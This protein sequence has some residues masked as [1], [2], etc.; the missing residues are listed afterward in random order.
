MRRTP[1]HEDIQTQRHR[2]TRTRKHRWAR[3]AAFT[4]IGLCTLGLLAALGAFAYLKVTMSDTDRGALA[5][6]ILDA[7]L[8]GTFHID[9]VGW[10]WPVHV[11]IEGVVINAPDGKT[12]AR[13]RSIHAHLRLLPLLRRRIVVDDIDVVEPNVTI[14]K[15][16]K[17]RVDI[18]TAFDAEEPG[19]E[20][21]EQAKP[22]TGVE[23]LQALRVEL[24]DIAVHHAQFQIDTPDVRIQAKDI[25]IKD[26]SL[27]IQGET[28]GLSL[29]LDTVPALHAGGALVL[30]LA[31]LHVEVRE[32]VYH[33]GEN[34]KQLTVDRVNVDTPG[35]SVDAGG[36]F[37]ATDTAFKEIHAHA[38]FALDSGFAF[39]HAQ[40]APPV[41]QGLSGQME[42][43]VKLEGVGPSRH[44]AVDIDGNRLAWRKLALA[45]LST[46]GYLRGSNVTLDT[47]ALRL[48]DALVNVHG[49]MTMRP[50]PGVAIGMHDLKLSAQNLAVQRVLGPFVDQSGL[51]PERVTMTLHTRGRSLWPMTSEVDLD[52]SA[53][54]VP[55]SW[56][57]GVPDPM[58]V[59]GKLITHPDAIEI[60]RLQFGSDTKQMALAGTI[61]FQRL[62]V[63]RVI[64]SLH[65][66]PDRP[67]RPFELHASEK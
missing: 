47:L 18:A 2:K 49:T 48:D 13:A 6:R 1:R 50:A 8:P 11:Q 54:G 55:A 12:V 57:P 25:E 43:R 24:Q 61:P 44:F 22:E 31:K 21:P 59:H 53:H 36:R 39:L 3:R 38:A 28:L 40:L 37:L 5:S 58:I 14:V 45:H 27:W 60:M 66:V 4:A 20:K 33:F 35:C 67:A 34:D 17:G 23:N 62:G 64:K 32:A 63:M 56:M 16:D 26:A 46:T 52:L 15:P 41:A 10:S 65:S 51:L 7:R 9:A 42:G 30:A 29:L 19:Q